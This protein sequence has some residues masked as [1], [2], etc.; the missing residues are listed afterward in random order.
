MLLF[1]S[2]T[3]GIYFN[4]CPLLYVIYVSR[5]QNYPYAAFSGLPNYVNSM[6]F[7]RTFYFFSF[8]SKLEPDFQAGSVQ[9]FP[10]PTGSAPLHLFYLLSLVKMLVIASP[11]PAPDSHD[12]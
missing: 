12:I 11:A 1:L 5:H 8:S 7:L 9:K 3:T 10:S 6:E 4:N 2:V